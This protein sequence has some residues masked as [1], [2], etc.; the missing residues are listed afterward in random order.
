[1]F[2]L[3]NSGTSMSLQGEL[4]APEWAIVNSALLHK[5]GRTQAQRGGTLVKRQDRFCLTET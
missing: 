1:M 4:R 5:Q 2:S 3:I